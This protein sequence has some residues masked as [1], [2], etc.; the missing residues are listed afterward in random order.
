MPKIIE[1]VKE[2]LL[3]EAKRQVAERGYANT[4]IRSVAGACGLGV[5]TVYNYFPSKEMLIASFVSQ[6]WKAHLSTISALPTDDARALLRAIYDAL[7]SFA[8]NNKRLFSDEDAAKVISI[9][10]ASRHQRLR[11][12]LADFILPVCRQKELENAEFAAQFVSE[13]LI[14]WAM[15]G[16][17]FDAV[18]NLLEKII[19]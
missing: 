18:Y 3:A 8:E 6:D 2:Q 12:Q 4:T 13:S 10:F 19:K 15:E 14:S 7:Q 17:E 11:N 16:I 9:G 1:N 5:G